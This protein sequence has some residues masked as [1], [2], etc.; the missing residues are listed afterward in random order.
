MLLCP[1]AHFDSIALRDAGEIFDEARL[2]RATVWIKQRHTTSWTREIIKV[3]QSV[4]M[5]A[6]IIADV[7]V[8][9]MGV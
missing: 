7:N 6:M 9:Q 1:L 2:F 8:E 3:V 5:F 4:H